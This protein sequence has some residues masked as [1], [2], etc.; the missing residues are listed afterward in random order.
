MTILN[1]KPRNNTKARQLHPCIRIVLRLSAQ[2]ED[3][4]QSHLLTVTREGNELTA[5]RSSRLTR[6]THWK[7]WAKAQPIRTRERTENIRPRRKSEAGILARRKSLSRLLLWPM[8]CPNN[9]P[10]YL[11][12]HS[13]NNR[14]LDTFY[15]I[16]S[17][18]YAQAAKSF[19]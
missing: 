11:K 18:F 8:L 19:L 14:L 9:P 17:L 1:L 4:F 16:P 3:L 13:A 7:D 6:G 12:I 10:Q 2:G 5:S 15:T